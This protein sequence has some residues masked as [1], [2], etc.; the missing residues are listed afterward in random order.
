MK[1]FKDKSGKFRPTEN[2]KG[3]GR[4]RDQ[5][6]KTQG[7]RL[8]RNDKF[9]TRTYKVWRYK[10]APPDV[11][12]KILD[13]W[14]NNYSAQDTFYA[15]D[16]GILYDT[17]E[18]F[19]GYEA[20]TGN[21]PKYWDL[22]RR[23]FIQFQLGIKDEKKLTKYL[24]IPEKLRTKIDIHFENDEETNTKIA[25]TDVMG[26]P[27]DLTNDALGYEENFYDVPKEDK[28]TLNEFRLLL[29]AHD[30]WAD[31]MDMSLKHLKDAYEDEFSEEHIKD[32]IEANDYK[33]TEDGKID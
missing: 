3:I 18:N 10:D 6:A 7:V 30:K 23:Q 32:T 26:N 29:Q 27:I 15:E 33:F 24:G 25:F 28:P 13:N 22:D 4:S 20:L 5:T 21:I 14:R 9:E 16:D 17:K 2:Q 11:Q 19:A 8:K 1:G 12:E 31:L